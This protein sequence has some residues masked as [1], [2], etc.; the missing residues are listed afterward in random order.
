MAGGEPPHSVLE[1]VKLMVFGKLHLQSL[2]T[3]SCQVRAWPQT[4]NASSAVLI[5]RRLNGAHEKTITGW[6]I[7]TRAAAM[8]PPA[9]ADRRTCYGDQVPLREEPPCA[10]PGKRADPAASDRNCLW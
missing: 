5:P 10:R 8:P 4:Q 1:A 7:S 3:R 2:R 9:V 6:P